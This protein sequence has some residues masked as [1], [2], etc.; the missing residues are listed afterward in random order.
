[1]VCTLTAVAWRHPVRVLA[2]PARLLREDWLVAA[3]VLLGVAAVVHGVGRA[4]RWRAGTAAQGARVLWWC[5]LA[6]PAR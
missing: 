3:V 6:P 1:M 2:R 4:V 5:L